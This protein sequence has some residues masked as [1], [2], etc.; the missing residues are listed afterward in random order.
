MQLKKIS[1]QMSLAACALLQV[2]SPVARAAAADNNW[3]VD[4][5]VLLYSESDGRVSVFEPALQA[6]RTINEDEQ[7]DVSVVFDALTGATPNGA[8]A[9]E[10]TQTFTS[11]SG[12]RSYTANPGETPLDSSFQDIRLAGS[13]NYRYNLDRLSRLTWGANLSGESDYLSLGGSVNFEQD[14]NQRNTTLMAGLALSQD[15][16]LPSGGVPCSLTAMPLASENEDDVFQSAG[17]SDD[18]LTTD[19]MFGVTQVLNRKT[20]FQANYS[21]SQSTGYLNDPSKIV[22]VID[23]ATGLPASSG[24]FNTALTRNL[25]YVYENR[26]DSRTRQSLYSKIVRYLNEDVIHLSYR[27]Y[28]DDWD[29]TSHTLDLKYRYQMEGDF[30]QP[31]VRLYQQS[32]A[33]FKQHDLQLG[34]DVDAATGEVLVDYASNDY[35]LAESQ[36]VTLGLKYGKLLAANQQFSMRAEWM[37]QTIQEPGVSE[38]EKTPGLDAIIV[39]FNYSIKF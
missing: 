1:G 5:A 21:Y 25:P 13:V 2:A 23:P 9:T 17:N 19:L 16:L 15:T 10:S 18:K 22:S 29:I 37:Q 32:A 31:H 27:Y 4:S 33:S 28:R 38:S 24:F 8:H 3:Q 26:P 14:I 7:I 30:L 20:L 6:T 36:T 12:N 11:A 34:R 39:Q 35:R